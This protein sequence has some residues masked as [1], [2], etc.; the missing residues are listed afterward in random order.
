MSKTDATKRRRQFHAQTEF[1]KWPPFRL[2]KKHNDAVRKAAAR[3][4]L[5]LAVVSEQALGLWLARQRK[6]A[7][8]ARSKRLLKTS[9]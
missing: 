2:T 4:G 9:P 5:S 8:L 6:R 1:V 7:K 3:A